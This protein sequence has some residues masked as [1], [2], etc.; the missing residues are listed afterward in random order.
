MVKWRYGESWEKFPIEWG[1][2]WVAGCNRIACGNG[3]DKELTKRLLN[4]I[5]VDMTYV[6]PPWNL[7]N[8]NSFNTK[9][10]F[11]HIDDFADFLLNLV[12]NIEHNTD[13]SIY[14]EM[15]KQNINLLRK[16]C[17]THQ[18]KEIDVYNILYYKK[19][20]CHLYYGVN[21]HS[22]IVSTDKLNDLDD[23]ITPERAILRENPRTI[24]D[25]CIGRGLTG[26]IAHK[27]NIV[28]YGIELNKRRVANLLEYYSKFYDV[29]EEKT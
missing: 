21:T 5:K 3:F 10:E 29:K 20:P 4:D 28:C 23:T 24:F 25:P 19:N 17:K 9:A 15:G 8:I 2:I 6:D 18:I 11:P 16:I 7:G 12:S 27:H 13:G 1:E 22:H 14:I 26:R